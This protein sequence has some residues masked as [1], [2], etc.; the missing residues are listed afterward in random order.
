LAEGTG[1]EGPIKLGDAPTPA[2]TAFFAS[3]HLL[4][5]QEVDHGFTDAGRETAPRSAAACRTDR[6]RLGGREVVEVD[7]AALRAG[8]IVEAHAAVD[9]A[10]LPREAF[11]TL[12]T[13]CS[14]LLGGKSA[15]TAKGAAA[16]DKHLNELRRAAGSNCVPLHTLAM[17][18][19]RHRALLFKILCQE[20]AGPSLQL[21]C[22]YI[23]GDY[24]NSSGVS[25]HAWNMVLVD[26]KWF[27]CDVMQRPGKLYPADKPDAAHYRHGAGGVG[28]ATIELQTP[29]LEAQM[30]DPGFI[31]RAHLV[32]D[33]DAEPLGAGSYGEVRRA[34]YKGH[35]ECAVKAVLFPDRCSKKE[36]K[37]RLEAFG[38]ELELLR[39]FRSPHIVQVR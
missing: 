8:W 25:G 33:P 2:A 39:G 13:L 18:V 14:K 19:C 12:A 36:K 6:P 34:T 26:G 23:R 7:L 35:Q 37:D 38:R 10:V 21:P 15:T 22:R 28:G 29:E 27:V 4:E 5:D 30:A 32:F 11:K 31:A 20:C 16:T 24:T 17:G 3:N 1:A 9:G